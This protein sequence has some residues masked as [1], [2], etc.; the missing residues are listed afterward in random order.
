MD[1]RQTRWITLA[2]FLYK[3]KQLCTN[4]KTTIMLLIDVF[5]WLIGQLIDTLQYLFLANDQRLVCK[6]NFGRE[7]TKL[8]SATDQYCILQ[9]MWLR[10]KF[11]YGKRRNVY[12]KRSKPSK[13][14]NRYSNYQ[15]SLPPCKDN[16]TFIH[17][18]KNK[19]NS[20]S[21]N[22]DMG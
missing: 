12:S 5:A 2:K 10:K 21:G 17:Q 9:G 22:S 14:K 11:H 20:V 18:G 16:L 8:N 7:V 1:W 6:K 19:P 3:L 13:I 15:K 4:K